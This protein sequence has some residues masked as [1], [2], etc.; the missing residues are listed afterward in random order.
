[1][2]VFC[3]VV[4][5]VYVKIAPPP[6][7]L[8]TDVTTVVGPPAAVATRCPPVSLWQLKSSLPSPL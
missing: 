1:M 5:G 7:G 2:R 3:H 6:R 4:E 8:V